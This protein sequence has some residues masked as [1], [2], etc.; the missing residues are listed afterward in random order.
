MNSYIIFII[1]LIIGAIITVIINIIF[2]PLK[3][4]VKSTVD[5]ECDYR[6]PTIYKIE[7]HQITIT[8]KFGKTKHINCTWF[9]NK[10]TEYKEYD[11]KKYF[12]CPFGESHD[13]SINKGKKC[14][15]V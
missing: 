7:T 1:G 2:S 8:K 11:G 15:F 3:N 5:A 6:T 9:R 4:W 13:T 14:P 12:Y 10:E